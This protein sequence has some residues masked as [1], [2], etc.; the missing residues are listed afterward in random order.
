M[1][2]IFANASSI[3]SAGKAAHALIETSRKNLS[4]LLNCTPRRLIFTSGA[5]EGNNHVIKSVALANRNSRNHVITSSIEHPSVR[6]ACKWLLGQGFNVPP[7]S[8]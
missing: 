1:R 2:G 3:H 7:S 8:E 4:L 6:G 5:S